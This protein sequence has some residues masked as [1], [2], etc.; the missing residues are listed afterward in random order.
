MWHAPEPHLRVLRNFHLA[1]LE[2]A[3]GAL[4]ELGQCCVCATTSAT[5][6]Y[7]L[8]VVLVH[9]DCMGDLFLGVPIQESWFTH[10][11]TGTADNVAHRRA[12]LSQ[13]KEEQ[14]IS[15]G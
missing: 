4:T 1:R 5:N 7:F 6:V 10:V 11:C 3:A 14:S 8:C 13:F 2:A 15:K 12:L 9:P